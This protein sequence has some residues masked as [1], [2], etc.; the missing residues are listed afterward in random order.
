MMKVDILIF[1]I[2]SSVINLS[3]HSNCDVD[4]SDHCHNEEFDHE[5][6]E[7][8]ESV[9][10]KAANEALVETNKNEEYDEAIDESFITEKIFSVINDTIQTDLNED[11]K[12]VGELEPCVKKESEGQLQRS[13]IKM[14][15]YRLQKYKIKERSREGKMLDL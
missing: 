10:V 5:D 7:A 1:F 14:G 4:G 8:V 13:L 2:L 3:R 15:G 11:D 9:M 6:E 12:I